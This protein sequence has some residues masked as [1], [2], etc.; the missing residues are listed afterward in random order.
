MRQCPVFASHKL[1][2][3]HGFSTHIKKRARNV[4][5]FTIR[6]P[7]CRSLAA[8]PRGSLRSCDRPFTALR[9]NEKPRYRNNEACRAKV[10]T[11]KERFYQPI[12][13]IPSGIRGPTSC[14]RPIS[15][16]GRDG[17]AVGSVV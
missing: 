17:V 13:S 16:G 15:L 7:F 11:R 3:P 1:R 14:R 8:I 6:Y 4:K 10:G 5:I 12:N 9:P 2:Q